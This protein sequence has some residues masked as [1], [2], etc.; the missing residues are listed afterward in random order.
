MGRGGFAAEKR[1]GRLAVQ[2]KSARGMEDECHSGRLD[3]PP[4]PPSRHFCG[5]AVR[6]RTAGRARFDGGTMFPRKPLL[7]GRGIL[8]RST[9]RLPTL[10]TLP[11]GAGEAA[12]P[13]PKLPRSLGRAASDRAFSVRGSA[14]SVPAPRPSSRRW[15]D[16]PFGGGRNRARFLPPKRSRGGSGARRIA[17]AAFGDFWPVKSRAP[18]PARGGYFP[19]VAR[20]DSRPKAGPAPLARNQ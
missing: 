11:G 14:A 3:A 8:A 20:I 1:T 4:G 18:V 2:E 13:V 17:P 9:T 6:H 10:G 16:C 7:F 12:S 5:N 15:G 19:R